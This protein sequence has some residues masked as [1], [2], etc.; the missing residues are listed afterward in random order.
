MDQRQHVSIC[1]LI[2]HYMDIEMTNRAIESIQSLNNVGDSQI[3]VVD[4]GSPNGSG[5][6]LE[7]KY[8]HVKE[9]HIILSALNDGFSAGNNLGFQYIQNNFTVDFVVAI[10]ND[11][12][13]PQKD[14]IDKL[15]VLYTEAPFWVAGPD[16]YV[17]HRDYHSSPMY[18]HPLSTEEIKAV[19]KKTEWEKTQFVKKYS[20]YGMKLYFRD[21]C[22]ENIVVKVAVKLNRMIRGHKK[23]YKERREGVV[24]QG[25][26][27]IFD[28]RYCEKNAKLFLPLTF[29]YGEEIILAAQ[30][31][32]NDW[33]IRYLPELLVWHSG[34]G[35]MQVEKM[36]YRN[37]LMKKETEFAGC[38]KAYKIY[39]KQFL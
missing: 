31:K 29:M 10:N 11:I 14:F 8:E 3:I 21:C 18:E 9:I 5:K 36:G 23:N 19:I 30:C 22:S 27:L 6:L 39:I 38:M 16:V 28:K 20:L 13:I 25:S 24:L 33:E 32:K 37:Y 12:L 2:L 7:Q 35:S 4:N 26:C 1:F 15:S 34:G 17:P